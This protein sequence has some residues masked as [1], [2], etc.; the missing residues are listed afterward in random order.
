[1]RLRGSDN[2]SSHFTL[3]LLESNVLRIILLCLLFNDHAAI[4]AYWNLTCWSCTSLR[5]FVRIAIWISSLS[6][7]ALI[8]SQSKCIKALQD[9]QCRIFSSSNNIGVYSM[10][11]D[12]KTLI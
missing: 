10:I 8:S 3:Q 2:S 9:I 1:M 4:L 5:N 7:Y 12:K 11:S 6:S